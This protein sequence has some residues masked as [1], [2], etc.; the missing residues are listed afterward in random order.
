MVSR[1][2]TRKTVAFGGS[3]AAALASLALFALPGTALPVNDPGPFYP[4]EVGHQGDP[5]RDALP[6]GGSYAINSGRLP[7]GLTLSSSGAVSGTPRE[8]GTFSVT[9]DSLQS[10]GDRY[11][12]RLAL[13]VYE[14]DESDLVQQAPSFLGLGSYSTRVDTIV[15]DVTNTFDG[16]VVRTGVRIVRPV[17]MSQA[18]PL[19]LFHRGRGFDPD[20]YTDFHERIASHGIAIASVEDKYSFSGRSFRAENT[21][22][23]AWYAELGM[24]SASGVVEAV[25]DYLLDRAADPT[26]GL[27]GSIDGDNLFFAGHSR[28]G[29]A[30]HASHQRSWNLRL[31]GLIYLMAFD[32]GYFGDL[33]PGGQPQ[34]PGYEIFLKNPRT[35]S[36]IIAAEN[37]GDL[38]Y[39]IADQLIDRATGP[40]TQVTVYGGVH[41]L[42]GDSQHRAEGDD[43]ITRR[44]EQ[45]RVAD[46]IV[47]FV[48]RWS[49]QD[50]GLDWRL[51]GGGNEGDATVGITSWRPSDRTLVLEDA[52]DADVSRNLRGSN[53]V[54]SAR[55]RERSI[56]PPVGDLDTLGLSHTLIEPTG[57]VSAWRM[58]SD[59]AMDLSKHQRLVMRV[60]QTSEFG[61]SGMGLWARMLD[62]RGGVSWYRVWEPTAGGHLPE[63]DGLSPNDRFVDVHVPLDGFFA[64]SSSAQGL[65][66]SQTVALDLFFVIRDSSRDADIVLDMIRFE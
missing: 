40:T 38:T 57:T 44:E 1:R 61:W 50:T 39:P 10:N 2:I 9:L 14:S 42:I 55:R 45:S 20:S 4:L 41:N 54:A 30:V 62:G 64:G 43:R 18:A 27:Y 34:S 7:S 24:E 19:L 3:C 48:K 11:P 28:G 25:S 49:E 13:T 52:Q 32:L 35:P 66:R 15:L 59:S 8:T 31:K 12:V 63:F 33:G 53:S 6:T 21:Q 60:S 16:A 22:Y 46:W 65:D 47:C 5:Y 51:Y 17:G 36:L 26:S 37:D 29:G 58:A 23:D 56:Y